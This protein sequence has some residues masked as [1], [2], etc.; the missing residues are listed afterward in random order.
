MLDFFSDLLAIH[1]RRLGF[2][3]ANLARKV[4]WKL[5]DVAKAFTLDL[6]TLTDS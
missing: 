4:L 3:K 2:T 1:F 6:L 5:L